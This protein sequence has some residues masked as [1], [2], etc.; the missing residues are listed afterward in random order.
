MRRI[1]A[2]NAE[3]KDSARGVRIDSHRGRSGFMAYVR[4]EPAV[5]G[6]VPRARVLHA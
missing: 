1:M 4:S 2:G 5:A 3:G 6:G